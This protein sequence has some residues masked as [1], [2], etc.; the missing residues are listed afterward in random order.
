MSDALKLGFAPFAAPANGRSHRVLRRGAQIR[1]CHRQGAG[2]RPPAWWRAR[3]R[4]NASPAKAA[5]RSNS[6][7]P[8]GL[9]VARLVVIGGGK[10]KARSLDAERSAQ[11]RRPR[12]GQAAACRQR[13]DRVRRIAE[14]RH[15]A[16]SRPPIWRKAC[17][18]A[19]MPSTATRPN[20]RTTRSRRNSRSVTIAVSDAA[21]ARKAYA[22]P[23][24]GRRRRADW[25]AI[26]STSRPMCS[27][28][29][30]SPAA[31]PALKKARRRGRSAR[32]QGN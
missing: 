17:G 22:S 16:P 26:S 11:A 5:R 10:P 32:P 19:P 14:R 20:A 3:P 2:L 23:R 12:H 25:R 9:K 31:R 27:T 7:V 28:R 21:A 15:E 8:E 24:S 18:C 13:S 1:P 4:P 30:N 6:V 29:K